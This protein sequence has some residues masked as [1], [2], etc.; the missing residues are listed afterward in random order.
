MCTLRHCAMTRDQW[1]GGKAEIRVRHVSVGDSETVHLTLDRGQSSPGSHSHSMGKSVFSSR[2]AIGKKNL[3]CPPHHR[4]P[5][6]DTIFIK[7]KTKL[8]FVGSE[9][10]EKYR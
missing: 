4:K 8:Y 5:A 3:K 9:T 10:R 2:G 1:P 7:I 6:S